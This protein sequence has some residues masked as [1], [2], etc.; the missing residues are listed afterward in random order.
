MGRGLLC[1]LCHSVVDVQFSISQNCETLT[2]LYLDIHE[3]Y[4][5]SQNLIQVSFRDLFMLTGQTK[6][7]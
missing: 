5:L 7:F 1:M 2:C 3:D 4:L 6:P